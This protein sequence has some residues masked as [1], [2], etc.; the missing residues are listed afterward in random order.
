MCSSIQVK[1]G[2]I[3]SSSIYTPDIPEIILDT[4]LS[5]FILNICH[6]TVFC[7]PTVY[8]KKKKMRS[9]CEKSAEPY[10]PVVRLIADMSM[11]SFAPTI[12]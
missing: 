7:N 6:C 9:V 2:K 1:A 10:V 3:F 4:Q 8:V 11:W 12:L 5:T